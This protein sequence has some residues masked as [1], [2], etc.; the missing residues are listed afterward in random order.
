MV[1]D[2]YSNSLPAILVWYQGIKSSPFIDSVSCGRTV[3]QQALFYDLCFFRT[4]DVYLVLFR[5]WR[6]VS[7]FK[8]GH[9][10]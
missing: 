3:T 6:A 8:V 10:S 7:G 2:Q 9:S 1:S 4:S 5:F